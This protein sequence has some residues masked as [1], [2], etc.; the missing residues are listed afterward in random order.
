M[1][2]GSAGPARG[3]APGRHGSAV[4]QWSSTRQF[5]LDN[6]KVILI[7]AIIAI[8][9]VL[10][11]AGTLDVWLYTEV[12]E[13]TLSPVAEAAMFVVVGPFA[14]FLIALLFLVAGLLTRPSLERKGPGRF[15]KDRLLR[16][17]V[18]FAV[19]V[20][21]LQPP[22]VYALEHPLGVAPRSYWFEFLGEPAQLDMGPLWFVGVLLI[23][24]LVYAGWVGVRQHRPEGRGFPRVRAAHLLLL[25]AAVAPATFLV[26]LVFPIGGEAGVQGLNFWEWPTCIVAFSLGVVGARQGWREALP[27]RLFRQARTV[28]L[29]GVAALGA[30]M[31]V[32]SALGV[33]DELTVRG[34]WAWATFVFITLE[35]ALT[36]FGPVWLLGVAQRY[37]NRPLR[38]IWPAARR[39]A[40]AAFMLQLLVLT[41][42]AVAM[43]PVPVAA[44]LKALVV[45]VGGVAGSFALA[46]LL[47][48]RVPGV[49]RIL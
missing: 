10:S 32:G 47:I 37:I 46:W 45:A 31:A 3:S 4:E 14:F 40:Y 22:V 48:S 5:Y 41:G 35:S 19:Y 34:G 43:R 39:S 11:Y 23:F 8:H 28:S 29:V 24:S 18:P 27:D 16:L 6:L 44:E 25:V 36:V 17:G 1:A 38:W 30:F 20:V 49:G 42:L 21:L 15:A 33:V 12:R 13:V 7:A 26:R 9:G 2:T